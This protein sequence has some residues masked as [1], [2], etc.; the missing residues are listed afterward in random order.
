MTD[1]VEIFDNIMGA[2][3]STA[4][5]AWMDS[6]PNEKYIYVSP[7]LSEVDVDGRIHNC[8]KNIEFISPTLEEDTRKIDH[9]NDLL[10]QGKNIACT[11]QLYLSMSNFSM[12]LIA[13]RGYIVVLDEEIN[14][15]KSYNKYSFK[16]IT[17]L[18]QE[19][20]IEYD[21]TNGAVSWVKEDDL[22]NDEDHSYFY[23]KNLC[24]KKSLYIT[25][26]DE[27]SQKAKRVMMVT[28]IPIRML[29]CAKRVIAITYMYKG[30]VLDCFLK[31]KGF[32]TKEFTDTVCAKKITPSY[33]KDLI[34]LVPPDD[35]TK[36]YA[37]TST[38]WD[39]KLT[40]KPCA[41]IR[42]Y[43]LRNAR[44]YANSADEVYWTLPK[45]RAK[46][47]SDKV[48]KNY[49]LINPIGFVHYKDKGGV[50]RPCWLSTHTRA[51]NMYSN[52]R[53]AIHCFNRYPLHDVDS[54]LKDYGCPIDAKVFCL[55]EVLQWFFRGCIRNEEPMVW[56]I[57]SK[58]VYDLVYRWLNELP[59]ED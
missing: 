6:N 10:V 12:D 3:K 56:C 4:I 54:Y 29:E 51:T 43:I 55:S 8:V 19:G 46:G 30:S 13:S 37:M 18:L 33:Y 28:Q 14:V 45:A 38:W 20:Y 7:N 31:L 25:R 47:A 9:L 39:S 1:T 50:K 15:M 16:D 57:A 23:C 21:K 48:R 26:F 44:K 17:W 53:V 49:Q 35:K 36:S 22:L 2:G 11:H 32:K 58:R 42:N 24:D 59:L 41:D 27:N 40:E 34:T 5:F 52:K